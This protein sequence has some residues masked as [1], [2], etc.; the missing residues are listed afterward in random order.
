MIMREVNTADVQA[1]WIT[2][3]LDGLSQSM[4]DILLLQGIHQIN[5]GITKIDAGVITIWSVSYT[6][7]LGGVRRTGIRDIAAQGL[8]SLQV[9]PIQDDI[10]DQVITTFKLKLPKTQLWILRLMQVCT[11]PKTL[12]FINSCSLLLPYPL[13]FYTQHLKV[14]Q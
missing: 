8:L 13:Q 2:P 7:Q 14:H 5:I 10:V 1:T 12:L 9:Q 3:G 11:P 6:L 4:A